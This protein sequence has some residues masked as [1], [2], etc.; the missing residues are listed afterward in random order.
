M[1]VLASVLDSC[2]QTWRQLQQRLEGISQ[3]EY[4]WEPVVGCWTV[5][6][7]PDGARADAEV[8]GQGWDEYAERPRLD[9]LL[10]AHREV[11]HHSAEIALLRDLYARR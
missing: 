11:T 9:L 10:H 2:D 4:A 3:D 6:Q 7:T 5:R 8:L 1:D